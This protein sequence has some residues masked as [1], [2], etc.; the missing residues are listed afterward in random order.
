MLMKKI[1]YLI[2]FVFA[3]V[4]CTPVNTDLQSANSMVG[5]YSCTSDG[6]LYLMKDANTR[7]TSWPVNM[8]NDSLIIYAS[9]TTSTIKITKSLV[10]DGA[11]YIAGDL[12]TVSGKD[13]VCSYSTL[14]QQTRK[15]NGYTINLGMDRTISYSTSNIIINQ[16]YTGSWSNGNLSGTISGSAKITLTKN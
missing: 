3:L 12:V 6:I 2:V 10:S 5:T 14:Y 8:T 15:L 16:T 4:S 1:I 9:N 13:W 11:I 7:Q